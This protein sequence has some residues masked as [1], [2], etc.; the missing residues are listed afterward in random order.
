[1]LIKM[2]I[3]NLIFTVLILQLNMNE[4]L[5]MKGSFRIQYKYLKVGSLELKLNF[6]SKLSGFVVFIKIT[7]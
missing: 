6:F 5:Y 3:F 1:M 4:I 7:H 2:F